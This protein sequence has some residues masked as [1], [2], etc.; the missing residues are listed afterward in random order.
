M[1]CK[2]DQVCIIVAAPPGFEENIGAMVTVR[3]YEPGFWVR[4]PRQ[5]TH[6]WIWDSASRPLV[7]WINTSDGGHIR[8]HKFHT[9]D[10]IVRAFGRELRLGL[11]DQHLIPYEPLQEPKEIKRI[12]NADL[13]RYVF[14]DISVTVVKQPA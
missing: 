2:P 7:A 13:P 3:R 11:Q 6:M 1:R 12:K 10:G 14:K 4:A 8:R 9:S 5:T